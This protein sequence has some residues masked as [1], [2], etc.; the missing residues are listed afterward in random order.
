MSLPSMSLP[1]LS[2]CSCC[3][4]SHNDG[5]C[6]AHHSALFLLLSTSTSPCFTMFRFS[7]YPRIPSAAVSQYTSL[8]AITHSLR[9]NATP[10]TGVITFQIVLI[11]LAYE[12]ITSALTSGSYQLPVSSLSLQTSVLATY[13][14]RLQSVHAL[15]QRTRARV[16]VQ[17]RERSRLLRQNLR[18]VISFQPKYFCNSHSS[19]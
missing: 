1:P 16:K 18:N 7:V 3:H 14:N 11:D 17:R 19:K 8:P 9:I 10:T 6:A 13:S 5:T 4:H 12:S 2:T 15:A